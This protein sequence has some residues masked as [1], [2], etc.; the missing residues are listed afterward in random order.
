MRPCKGHSNRLVLTVDADF[1]LDGNPDPSRLS[2]RGT[3]DLNGGMTM[4]VGK[5]T[6]K[7]QSEFAPSNQEKRPFMK[8]FR[9]LN[10]PDYRYIAYL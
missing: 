10:S 5:V 6:Y 3:S 7:L 4:V 9:K 2:I 1:E 8:D